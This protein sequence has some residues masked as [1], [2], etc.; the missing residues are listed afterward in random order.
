MTQMYLIGQ[1]SGFISLSFNLL[2]K[3]KWSVGMDLKSLLCWTL[4]MLYFGVDFKIF[5]SLGLFFDLE[6]IR[7]PIAGLSGLENDG[8]FIDFGLDSSGGFLSWS[9]EL[10]FW[11][12]LTGWEILT[13]VHDYILS[14]LVW[15]FIN[16]QIKIIDLLLL[17]K[18]CLGKLNLDIL[19]INTL[20][21]K[22]I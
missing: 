21:I 6:L 4:F 1:K 15:Q 16:Y 3:Y 11:I 18:D 12:V 8:L 22:F 10:D 13:N 17:W 2:V 20:K 7:G 19:S 14:L 5:M 9:I